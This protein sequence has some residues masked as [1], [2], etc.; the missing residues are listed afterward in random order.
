MSLLFDRLRICF[1]KLN[2]LFSCIAI[3]RSTSRRSC[4]VTA[5]AFSNGNLF[6]TKQ[7]HG[8]SASCSA[9][10]SL[11]SSTSNMVDA[12]PKPR[13]EEDRVVYAGAAPEGWDPKV[14]RQANDSEEKL[15][16]PPVA[17]ADPY[18]YMRDDKRENKEVLDHLHAENAY[19][20]SVTK[21][22]EVSRSCRCGGFGTTYF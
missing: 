17:I 1:V 12:P 3:F 4:A 2:I 8:G 9:P 20:K 18:G 22:L 14:P 7:S 10:T 19:T 15:M 5:S 6:T 13:R 16:D 11:F 21:H